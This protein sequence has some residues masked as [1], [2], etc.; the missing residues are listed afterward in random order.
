MGAGK[1]ITISLSITANDN[2]QRWSGENGRADFEVCLPF[3]SL[4][5]VDLAVLLPGLVERARED[6]A[7]KQAETAAKNA[8]D[9]ATVAEQD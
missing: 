5:A 1:W 7:T 4:K 9:A 3:V 8:A 2:P 6:L